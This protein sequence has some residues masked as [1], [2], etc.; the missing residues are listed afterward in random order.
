MSA[1]WTLLERHPNHFHFLYSG[2]H[3]WSDLAVTL[4]PD[5]RE[6][7]TDGEWSQGLR[8]RGDPGQG[9]PWWPRPRLGLSP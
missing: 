4:T 1:L 5:G 7:R 2:Q 3:I 9:A 8:L 6:S